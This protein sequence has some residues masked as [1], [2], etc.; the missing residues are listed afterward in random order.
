MIR[1]FL[2]G[3]TYGVAL[4]IVG[5]VGLAIWGTQPPGSQPPEAPLVEAPEAVASPVTVDTVFAATDG[6]TDAAN[7][8][9]VSLSPAG[10]FSSAASEV[11][12][13]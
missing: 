2:L 4:A 3:I 7:D 5:L 10:S 12:E 9:T 11:P 6:N 13:A 8:V 1:G